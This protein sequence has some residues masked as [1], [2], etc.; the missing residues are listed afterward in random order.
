MVA[1]ARVGRRTL[2]AI[3]GVVYGSS[4]RQGFIRGQRFV[5]PVMGFDFTVLAGYG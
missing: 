2:T 5:H 1:D 4:R 3:D